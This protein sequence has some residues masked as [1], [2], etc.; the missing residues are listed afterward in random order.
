MELQE[1]I[2]SSIVN[3]FSLVFL[4]PSHIKIKFFL[5]VYTIS[6]IQNLVKISCKKFPSGKLKKYSWHVP[7]C[8]AD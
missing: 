8:N 2:M 6:V 7:T 5:L 3:V 4:L 1:S